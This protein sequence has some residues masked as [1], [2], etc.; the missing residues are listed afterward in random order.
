MKKQ[1]RA[2][3]VPFLVLCGLLCLGHACA[4]EGQTYVPAAPDYADTAM[5]YT[6]A[7]GDTS[8][9]ADVFYVVSTW[10]FDWKTADGRL[11][12]YAD[13][14]ASRTHRK[15][16]AIEQQKAAEYMAPGN[17]FFAP[18]YRHVT[19]QT[20]ATLNEDTINR[21]Y[22]DVSFADVSRSFDY[23]LRHLNG[24]RPFVL[25]GFSQGGKSVVELV[26]T[27]PAEARDRM[28]A[29]YVMGYKVTPQDT[30]ECRYL[31]AARDSADI[32]VTVCYNSVKDVRYIQP[33][34]S[35]PCAMCINPVNWRT[36]SVPA[37]L[38]DTVTVAV[39]PRHHVLVVSGYSASEYRPILGFLNVG[40]IHGCEPW[41]YSESL[42][43]NIRLRVQRFRAERGS[44]RS[45]E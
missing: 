13:P 41:L 10:E 28:V 26:K 16:M 9:G 4:Q 38:H 34:V 23:Y 1:P 30:A 20:W 6:L 25:A 21:R 12:H 33:V 5:W 40:D 19:L 36:D 3:G 32:G 2:F 43:R 27:M 24:G 44:A 45:E 14:A 11:C 35:A 31:K 17:R 39:S 8:R 7:E 37:T 29:A 15:R 42:G 22:R 18:Y